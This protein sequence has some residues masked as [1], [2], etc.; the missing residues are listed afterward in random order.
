MAQVIYLDATVTPSGVAPMD[1][2]QAA[3]ARARGDGWRAA[4]PQVP[5]DADGE[6]S[7]EEVAWINARLRQQQLQPYTEAV[8]RTDPT[9]A[10]LPRTFVRFTRGTDPKLEASLAQARSE[11]WSCLSLDLPHIAIV[12]DPREIAAVL[13]ALAAGHAP[14]DAARPAGTPQ[15][16]R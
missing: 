9:A 11:G 4:L 12:T 13:L 7:P 8:R 15:P 16:R 6:R 1:D 2:Q 5:L 3:A 14:L 10:A